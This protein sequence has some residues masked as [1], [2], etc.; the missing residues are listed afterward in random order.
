MGDRTNVGVVMRASNGRDK[1]GILWVYSHWGLPGITASIAK[2]LDNAKGR[3]DDDMYG[4]RIFVQSI[5]EAGGMESS[6]ELGGG[7]SFN[8][9]ADNEHKLWV[10]DFYDQTMYLFPEYEGNLD[11]PEPLAVISFQEFVTTYLK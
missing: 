10:A 7:L 1:E 6:S 11:T 2:A 8:F 9:I 5:M 3:W 4:Q